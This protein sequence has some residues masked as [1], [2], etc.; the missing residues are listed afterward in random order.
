MLKSAEKLMEMAKAYEQERSNKEA[1]IKQAIANANRNIIQC[2]KEM[3]AAI[4]SDNEEAFIA[5]KAKEAEY[6]N[7]LE[8]YAQVLSNLKNQDLE[9]YTDILKEIYREA[10]AQ[11]KEACG[12]C[13]TAIENLTKESEKAEEIVKEYN[14]A[15]SYF[16]EYIAFGKE[17]NV[18]IPNYFP[19]TIA[20]G[21]TQRMQHQ[22]GELKKIAD[23]GL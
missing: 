4:K 2:Q 11:Y 17:T 13:F 16:R 7:R 21:I 23:S 19:N 15:I 14:K 22:K 20:V 12:D 18:N 9:K 6:N 1:E 3:N 8:Y 5:S 10:I